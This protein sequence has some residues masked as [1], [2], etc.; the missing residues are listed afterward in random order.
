MRAW[1]SEGR[2]PDAIDLDL[3]RRMLPDTP[4][5]AGC[6]RNQSHRWRIGL[7][8]CEGMLAR[9]SHD[10]AEWGIFYNGNSPARA[11]TIHHCP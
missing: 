4:Y 1:H 5:G 9:S 2:A 3:V 6:S 11:P 10:D 7:D 8:S